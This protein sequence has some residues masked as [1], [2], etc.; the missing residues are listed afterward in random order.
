MQQCEDKWNYLF[1][2]YTSSHK[3]VV[4][5]FLHSWPWPRLPLVVNTVSLSN[6]LESIPEG[7]TKT[8]NK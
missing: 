8:T 6:I 1:Q 3:V 5:G 2:N 7:N 4:M